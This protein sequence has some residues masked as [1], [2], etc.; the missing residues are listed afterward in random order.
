MIYQP[1]KP[2]QTGRSSR[3]WLSYVQAVLGTASSSMRQL[4]VVGHGIVIFRAKN[5]QRQKGYIEREKL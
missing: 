4:C 1:N 2:K 5:S 3:G